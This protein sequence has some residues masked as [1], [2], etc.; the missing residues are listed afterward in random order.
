MRVKFL[1]QV[2]DVTGSYDIGQVVELSGDR[3]GQLIKQGIAEAVA[4]GAHEA[5]AL[6][7]EAHERATHPPSRKRG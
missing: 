3:A 2:S 5:A 1:Q 6:D 4:V 7:D